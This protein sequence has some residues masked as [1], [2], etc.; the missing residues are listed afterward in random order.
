[1]KVSTCL[2]FML[3]ADSGWAILQGGEWGE[4]LCLIDSPGNVVHISYF[5]L[6]AGFLGLWWPPVWRGQSGL[7]PSGRAHPLQDLQLSSDP[8]SDRQGQ[9]WSLST[10]CDPPQDAC[11]G[12]CT[13][14]AWF[15][16]SLGPESLFVCL[17]VLKKVKLEGLGARGRLCGHVQPASNRHLT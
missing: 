6:F 1:M 8:G 7:L 16:S 12:N 17:F 11:W 15:L 5:A 3:C 2:S 4:L 9:H 14:F 10:N 13:S